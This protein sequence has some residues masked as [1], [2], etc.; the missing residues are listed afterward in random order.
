[1]RVSHILFG[2]VVCC[3]PPFIQFALFLRGMMIWCD[4]IAI[5]SSVSCSA[6]LSF[7]CVCV[8]FCLAFVSFLLTSCYAWWMNEIVC[9]HF[10]SRQRGKVEIKK[11]NSEIV[12][13]LL[14]LSTIA[15]V[16]LC[17][18]IEF[19]DGSLFFFRSIC[20]LFHFFEKHSMENR[21]RFHPLGLN[22]WSS[23]Q[24][25]KMWTPPRRKKKMERKSFECV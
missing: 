7:V 13:D 14:F 22:N 4:P 18:G 8:C 23:K 11:N 10:L 21:V 9:H 15:L 6:F 25:K 17:F 3:C 1:M 5:S 19:R 16:Q 20:L 12:V 24:N 2:F